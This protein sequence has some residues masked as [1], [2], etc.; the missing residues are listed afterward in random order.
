MS[1]VRSLVVATLMTALVAACAD[2]S[3]PAASAP[4]AADVPLKMDVPAPDVLDVPAP[5]DGVADVLDASAPEDVSADVSAEKVTVAEDVAPDVPIDRGPPP[6]TSNV[7]CSGRACD[8]STG[9]CVD[10]TVTNDLCPPSR[11]CEA[12]TNVCIDGCRAD[13]G[14]AGDADVGTRARRCDTAAHRCVECLA[15]DDCPLGSLCLGQT[16]RPGCDATHG[17]PSGEGCCDGACVDTRVNVAACG[18]CGMRCAVANA[19]AACVAGACA[20]AS[21]NDTF[22]DCDRNATNGCE[23]TVTNSNA[24]CGMCG[25]ACSNGA[26]CMSGRCVCPGGAT[27][28]V[29]GDGI[30]NDCDGRSDCT[31]PDCAAT[32]T[33]CE[34]SGRVVAF[35]ASGTFT[36]PAGV[37]ALVVKAWGGG[38]GGGGSATAGAAT[39]GAAATTGGDAGPGVGAAVGGGNGAASMTGD[40]AAGRIGGAGCGR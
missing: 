27:E 13:E 28:T 38:G 24:H 21:C 40:G 25:N 9:R 31:D 8:T 4:D 18:G 5:L 34:R 32:M 22:G 23:V 15:S 2:K 1:R 33:C 20:V 14:C 3:P 19:T 16:C 36:V 37:T 35:T 29:C 17:C 10:C 39:L 6:C 11:H 7:D 12:M 26:T 30:D